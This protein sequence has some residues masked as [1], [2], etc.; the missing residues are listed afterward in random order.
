MAPS[1]VLLAMGQNEARAASALRLSLAHQ[2]TPDATSMAD[3]ERC[4]A[5][6]IE[7]HA[8]VQAL[9]Q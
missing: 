2:G 9:V 7:A 3:V 1:A 4:A 6:V 5:A 8:Q